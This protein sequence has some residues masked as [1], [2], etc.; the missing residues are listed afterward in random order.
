M[1]IGLALKHMPENSNPEFIGNGVINNDDAVETIIRD[2]PD[3]S[4]CFQTPWTTHY[5]FELE[6]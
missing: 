6:L 3:L 5:L 2:N 1:R 4:V